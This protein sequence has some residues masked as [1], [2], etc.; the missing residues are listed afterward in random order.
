MTHP[1]VQH[2]AGHLLIGFGPPNCGKDKRLGHV[3]GLSPVGYVSCGDICRKEV[4]RQTEIGQAIE[5]HKRRTG[6]TLAPTD[7]ILPSILPEIR[8]QRGQN[9]TVILN[10]FCRH[11]DQA[12]AAVEMISQFGFTSL[13]VLWFKADR[14]ECVARAQK[15]N[16]PDDALIEQRFDEYAE[17]SVPAM[18]RLLAFA[19]KGLPIQVLY[20]DAHVSLREA[21]QQARRIMSHF[22]LPRK[23]ATEK[24]K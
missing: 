22:C 23:P 13:G 10:G 16:R 12:D 6:S 14:H 1:R 18:L 4:E 19:G 24:K 9:K 8:K 3:I 5:A 20:Y 21:Y 17:V 11:E 2:E 15:R 7:I